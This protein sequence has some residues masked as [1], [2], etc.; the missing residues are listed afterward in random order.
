VKGARK[1]NAVPHGR[2]RRNRPAPGYVLFPMKWRVITPILGTLTTLFGVYLLVRV[3]Q[4]YEFAEIKMALA[5][6]PAINLW[7]AGALSMTAF[8]GFALAEYLGI[9]YAARR[10][11]TFPQII[12]VTVAALGIGHSL[13]LAALS[14]GAVRY[15]MYS[16]RGISL[17]A[18]AQV[19]LFSGVTVGM[20]IMV[21][22]TAL[23]ALNGSVIAELLGLPARPLILTAAVFALILLGYPIA[24]TLIRRPLH[25]RKTAIRFPSLNLA[26]A[27]IG[28]GTLNVL[29]IGSA[30]YACL[31][32]FTS[33]GFLSVMTLYVGADAA[34]IV[35]HVPG[36][37]GV[38]E[39]VMLHF[40][41]EP[42]L[43]AGV[44]AFRAVYYLVPL[45]V[46]LAIFLKDESV[47]ALSDR[48]KAESGKDAASVR[49]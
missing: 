44:V 18:T 20:G 4:R 28:T 1:E 7:L 16:R 32:P 10:C 19:I 35:G 30:L 8:L 15:R 12:L 9:C 40:L 39:Y 49:S 46:A 6:I 13:G 38:L 25:I 11:L 37:W 21:V 36:G 22:S 27:Q 26:L 48:P 2:F 17:V 14:S 23:L 31:E 33:A 29:L 43:I 34:A 45:I 41:E 5:Q 42:R 47:N 24:C 3:F